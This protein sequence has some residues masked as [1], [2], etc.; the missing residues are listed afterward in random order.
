[1][2]GVACLCQAGIRLLPLLIACVTGCEHAC[3]GLQRAP[4]LIGECGFLLQPLDVVHAQAAHDR[5]DDG[6][7]D[8]DFKRHHSSPLKMY[9]QNGIPFGV[10]TSVNA[11]PMR[12]HIS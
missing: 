8:F 3:G 10:V 6:E 4:A 9:F 11:M 5:E 2:R 7:D 1:M 12:N